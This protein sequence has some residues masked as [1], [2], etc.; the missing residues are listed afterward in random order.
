M[1]A[2]QQAD[3]ELARKWLEESVSVQRQQGNLE[4][5]AQSLHV[6]GHVVLDELDYDGANALFEELVGDVSP[7][8]G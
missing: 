7:V 8:W 6:L 4:D 3:T 5:L 1:L 2:M